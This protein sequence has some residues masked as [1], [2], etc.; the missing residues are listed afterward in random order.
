MSE[1]LFVYGT[2]LPGAAP[3]E[4]ASA[5]AQLVP[6]GT[7]W[8]RGSLYDL[9]EFPGAILEPSSGRRIVGNVFLLPGNPA[10]LEALDAYEEFD[11]AAPEQSQFL[12]VRATAELSTGSTLEC[13]IYVFNQDVRSAV[14]IE[15]G[16]WMS[17]GDETVP[18]FL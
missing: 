13:W 11:P 18:E 3:A 15:C 5:A 2:L 9:G 8:V 16:D 17:R 1:Y 12:R 10:V 7:G 6:V 14:L 4:I